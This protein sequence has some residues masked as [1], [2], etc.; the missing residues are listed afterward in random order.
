MRQVTVVW[1]AVFAL[2]LRAVVPIGTPGAGAGA[3][4]PT[5]ASTISL[6]LDSN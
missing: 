5:P 4:T 1:L 2:L 6:H 3:A